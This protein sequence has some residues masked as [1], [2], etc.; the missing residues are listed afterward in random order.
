VARPAHNDTRHTSGQRLGARIQPFFFA[1]IPRSFVTDEPDATAQ[2][3]DAV[4]GQNHTLL[5]GGT[6]GSRISFTS[7]LLLN[8]RFTVTTINML[9]ALDPVKDRLIT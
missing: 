3:K 4:A 2:A 9:I 6:A 8:Y 7:S 1:L 5:R